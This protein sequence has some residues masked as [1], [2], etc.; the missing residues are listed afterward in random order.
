MET[1]KLKRVG[2]ILFAFDSEEVFGNLKL[3]GESAL[4][5]LLMDV[6][7]LTKHLT[8]DLHTDATL[9]TVNQL[10]K[11]IAGLL[12]VILMKKNFS[13]DLKKSLLTGGLD[14]Y[15]I[16]DQINKDVY[17]ITFDY[18]NRKHILAPEYFARKD[19]VFMDLHLNTLSTLENYG[20]YLSTLFQGNKN[21]DALTSIIS[22]KKILPQQYP[23]IRKIVAFYL[24]LNEE[25]PLT[26]PLFD[27]ID[28]KYNEFLKEISSFNE[29]ETQFINQ[30]KHGVYE[31]SLLFG[32]MIGENLQKHPKAL[33][34]AKRRLSK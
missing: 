6:G 30:F 24:G 20:I 21:F 12:P 4:Q 14:D 28:V 18:L 9:E 23:F 29:K 1:N 3:S 16:I 8:F 15:Y 27:G 33:V 10:R 32:G 2:D 19:D 31:P 5:F 17:R 26:E 13:I 22:N 7:L 34:L 25:K 11:D